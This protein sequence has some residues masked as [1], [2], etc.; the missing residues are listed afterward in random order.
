MPD[1]TPRAGGS[2]VWSWLVGVVALVFLLV[3][4]LALWS[5]REDAR[6]M[7]A[8]VDRRGEETWAPE[9]LDSPAVPGT[10]DPSPRPGSP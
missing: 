5:E 3:F 7:P 1:T 6:R 4:A 9:P 8:E 2:R 10:T